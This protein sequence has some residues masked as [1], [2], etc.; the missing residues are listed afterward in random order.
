MRK[1]RAFSSSMRF[2]TPS[3]QD[4]GERRSFSDSGDMNREV[5]TFANTTLIKLSINEMKRSIN[6]RFLRLMRSCKSYAKSV[7]DIQNLGYLKQYMVM[8]ITYMLSEYADMLS[9]NPSLQLTVYLKINSVVPQAK[10]SA[11]RLSKVMIIASRLKKSQ[12]I[13]PSKNQKDLQRAMDEFIRDVINSVINPI[14]P[15]TKV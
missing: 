6:I 3:E 9:V 11:M 12:G 10:A 1:I 8:Q 14:N 5:R 4:S 13:L 7:K 2:S 15:T